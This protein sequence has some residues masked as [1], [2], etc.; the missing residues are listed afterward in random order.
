MNL[1]RPPQSKLIPIL[2]PEFVADSV[3][4]A[5][6]A[7]KEILLLPWWAMFLLVL[8]VSNNSCTVMSPD[9]LIL[10]LIP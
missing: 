3:V 4:D 6:M 5:T 9:P 1:V 2:E 8:K 10:L 7:N